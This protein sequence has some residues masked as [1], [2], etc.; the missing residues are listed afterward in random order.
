MAVNINI[1]VESL[2]KSMLTNPPSQ[3]NDQSSRAN[4]AIIS[5]PNPFNSN[6]GKLSRQPGS[7]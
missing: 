7:D 2:K 6:H 5:A 4:A 1:D 3:N